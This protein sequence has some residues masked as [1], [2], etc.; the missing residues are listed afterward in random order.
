M[1]F[2]PGSAV[3]SKQLTVKQLDESALGLFNARASAAYASFTACE[4]CRAWLIASLSLVTAA[5]CR[6]TMGLNRATSR[7]S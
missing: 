1:A 4:A 7:R 3:A 6:A 2:A 5:L